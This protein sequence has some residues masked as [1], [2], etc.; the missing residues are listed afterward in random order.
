MQTEISKQASK[1]ERK[2]ENKTSIQA[3]S[4][5]RIQL[6]RKTTKTTITKPTYTTPAEQA[7]K[8]TRTARHVLQPLQTA[9]LV[10]NNTLN[11]PL[12]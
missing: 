4:S 2:N 1:Q 11:G 6:K 9:L 12:C 8:M 5:N 7:N 10:P 3:N